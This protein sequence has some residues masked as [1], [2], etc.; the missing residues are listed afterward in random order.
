[1]INDGYIFIDNILVTLMRINMNTQGANHVAVSV[2]DLV[3]AV[4]WYSE[5]MGFTKLTEPTEIVV[6]NSRLGSIVR[7]CFGPSIR[8]LRIAHLNFGDQVGLELFEFVEPKAERT[9]NHFEYSKTSFLHIAVTCPNI[10]QFAKQIV[11]S[12]GKQ[13][14]KIWELIDGKPFKIV[15]CEDPFG[16]IIEL[17]SHEFNQVWDGAPK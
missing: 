10:E 8:K 5:V 7:D 15:F 1:M 2:P 16:N 3:K 6:D 17:Y 11:E 13:R 14:S 9:T 12:G 4:R